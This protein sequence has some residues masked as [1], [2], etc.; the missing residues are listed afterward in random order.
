MSKYSFPEYLFYISS[1]GKGVDYFSLTQDGLE[2]GKALIKK[3]N[4]DTE[5]P[6]LINSRERML[7]C[8]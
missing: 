3:H 2:F 8:I 7:N 1:L 5:G 6:P 4:L